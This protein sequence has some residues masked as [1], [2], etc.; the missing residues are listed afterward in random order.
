MG[1]KNNQRT[2]KLGFCFIQEYVQIY[3]RSAEE[4]NVKT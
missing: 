2:T 1:D 4:P 3:M